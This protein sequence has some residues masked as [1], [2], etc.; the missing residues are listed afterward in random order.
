[1]AGGGAA[2]S[3][4]RE[5]DAR[6]HLVVDKQNQTIADILATD[7]SIS[8]DP[9]LSMLE[10]TAGLQ[11]DAWVLLGD[12]TA[13]LTV[14]APAAVSQFPA[15]FGTYLSDPDSW[16]LHLHDII[17]LHIFTLGSLLSGALLLMGDDDSTSSLEM[18]NGEQVQVLTTTSSDANSGGGDVII[19]LSSANTPQ[20]P[21]LETDILASNGVV[22]TLGTML[23]PVWYDRSLIQLAV[24]L[25]DVWDDVNVSTDLMWMAA[26]GGL[27]IFG[28]E[29]TAFVPTDAAWQEVE[30]ETL[31]FY[32]DP[33]NLE[34]LVRLLEGHLV[35]AVYPS[36]GA[37][38][39]DVLTTVAGTQIVVSILPR[40][41]STTTAMFNDAVLDPRSDL[42][43]S[44]GLAHGI[45][46]VWLLPTTV[47]PT[48]APTTTVAPNQTPTLSPTRSITDSPS[49][50]PTK[51]PITT[52]PT[53]MT[54]PIEPTNPRDD[55][56]LLSKGA[57]A[58]IAVGAFVMVAFLAVCAARYWAL[59]KKSG[60]DPF[61]AAIQAHAVPAEEMVVAAPADS[62]GASTTTTVTPDIIEVLPPADGTDEGPGPE[63]TTPSVLLPAGKKVEKP[64]MVPSALPEYK[65]QVRRNREENPRAQ[66]HQQVRN[67]PVPAYKDQVRHAPGSGPGS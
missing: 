28:N 44:N 55:E 4:A 14:F 27:T 33:T 43:A 46:K 34:A 13:N 54:I 42:L 36:V 30:P 56:R 10:F 57:T 18:R 64:D 17:N 61:A 51:A 59:S 26:Q 67:T 3:A 6:R 23:L 25:D 29:L 22:H 39:G 53:E 9:F 50:Q 35:E 40:N 52:H 63:T 37:K 66:D 49:E 19:T 15:G 2:Y 65:D 1:M 62:R 32:Q 20:A 48:Q 7:P 16:I 11:D 58:G 5:V 47:S 41:N 24:V 45:N 8:F 12:P 38:D 21:V 60:D 31:E